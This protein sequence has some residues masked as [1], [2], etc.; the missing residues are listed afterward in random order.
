MRRRSIA[1]VARVLALAAL[2]ALGASGSVRSASTATVGPDDAA[3]TIDLDAAS[4]VDPGTGDRIAVLTGGTIYH[5]VFFATWCPPCVDEIPLLADLHERWEE[6]GYAL[7]LVAISNR[8]D[9]ERVFEFAFQA[10]V[11]GRVVLDEKDVLRNLLDVDR[12]PTH[13]L[14]DDRGR[15][16]LRTA[17]F[18]GRIAEVV[19]E[20]IRRN[21]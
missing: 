15:V 10:R 2:V 1:R 20:Q 9:R 3:A 17:G 11:P 12:I 19:G 16:L 14:I 4:A 13:L 5:V 7:V 18:E 6:D 8:Q 21:R